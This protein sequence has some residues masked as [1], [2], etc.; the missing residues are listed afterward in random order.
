M[1]K[2]PALL[3]CLGLAATL[4][5]I[6]SL[7]P[8]PLPATA[9]ESQFSAERALGDVEVLAQHPHPLGS[10]AHDAAAAYLLERMRSL[11]LEVRTQDGVA[12]G[13]AV[14][15]LIGVLPGRDRAVPAVALM[16]HYDTAPGSPG[17]ADDSTGVA[18]ALEIVRALRVDGPAA[19]DVALVITDGEEVDLLGARAF[20]AA[21]PLARRIGLVLNMEARG[22]GG[23]VFMFETGP[24]NGALIDVF[25]RVTP[26]PSSN[27]LAIFVY[28]HMPNDT[29]FTVVKAHGGTGLNYA[30]IGRQVDYHASTSTLAR[31]EQGSVQHMGNQVLAAAR[32]FATAAELPARRADRVYADFLGIGVLAYAPGTGWLILLAA[33]LLYAASALRLRR[34]IRLQWRAAARGAAAT[35]LVLPLAAALAIAARH[36]TGVPFGFDSQRPLLAA[37]GVYETAV[38]LCSLGLALL[39]AA[40]PKKAN[41]CAWGGALVPG[42]LAAFGAQAAV[43]AVAF[44]LAWPLLI[45]AAT[46]WLACLARRGPPP[47]PVNALVVAGAAAS[48]SQCL[49]LAHAVMLGVGANLP[50]AAGLYAWLGALTLFPLLQPFAA[51]RAGALAGLGAIGLGLLLAASFR[52]H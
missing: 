40:W 10:A 16:A 44:L 46:S 49:Y 31:L 20:Y 21:D 41:W 33:A 1:P 11:G 35:L 8:R 28:R 32:A 45:A 23:R 18:V 34:G 2:L 47:D 19:R 37:W 3:A 51:R 26:N 14:R 24:E 43:P 52:L 15:N 42:F 27:S 17:A 30:F 29:D 22:G 38:A 4:A 48:L 6:A 13:K 12:G 5:W 9:P 7:P 25:R 36:L 39:L 50:A